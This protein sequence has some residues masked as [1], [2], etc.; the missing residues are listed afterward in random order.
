MGIRGGVGEGKGR[1]RGVE[2]REEE[3]EL[4]EDKKRSRGGE[5]EE[6]IQGVDKMEY[7]ASG[8]GEEEIQGSG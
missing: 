3:V 7:R 8:E 2:W 6:E 1:F 5:G 4:V